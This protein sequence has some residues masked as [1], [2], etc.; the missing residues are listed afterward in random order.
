MLP[1]RHSSHLNAVV[2]WDGGYN[3]ILFLNWIKTASL[4]VQP[5]IIITDHDL[6]QIKAIKA[7]YLDSQ[8]FLCI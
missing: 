4:G 5:S 6:A 1:D 2:Q 7:V 8:I 3:S